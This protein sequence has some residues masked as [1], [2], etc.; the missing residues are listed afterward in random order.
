[1]QEGENRKPGE[2]E[3][4]AKKR[5]NV[6]QAVDVALAYIGNLLPGASEILVEEVE[7]SPT[8]EY[9]VLTLS[10]K[11]T[12]AFGLWQPTFKKFTIDALTGEVIS[13]KR[14]KQN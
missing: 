13:M 5:L 14:A 9:W 3:K 8:K 12:S 7:I 6:K 11:N 2:T 1:M 10:M 4:S